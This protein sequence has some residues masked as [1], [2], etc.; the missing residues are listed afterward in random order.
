MKLADE[1]RCDICGRV[2]PRN[3][4]R[5]C[6]VRIRGKMPC[7]IGRDRRGRDFYSKC[8]MDICSFCTNEISRAS[9]RRRQEADN[10][11]A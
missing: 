7:F 11:D 1:R 10:I 5:S 3:E 2:F 4:L 8:R 9:L 6:Q